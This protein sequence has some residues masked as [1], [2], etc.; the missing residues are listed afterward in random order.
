M[1]PELVGILAV[2]VFF[3]LVMLRVP[4]AFA[5]FI[6]SASGII[7]LVG[8]PGF[9]HS[10][11]GSTWSWGTNFVMLAVPL[12]ILMGSFAF[13]GGLSRDLYEVL[14]KLIGRLPGGLA[15]ASVGACAGFA[16]CSGS[17]MA[18]V[19]SVGKVSYG[20]M[21]RFNYSPRLATGCIAAGGTLGTIIPPSTLLII[22]GMLTNTSVGALFMA[23]I[24]PGLIIAGLYGSVILIRAIRSP[25]LAP[26]GPYVPWK[27]RLVLL[28]RLLPAAVLVAIIIGG[29][30]GGVFTPSEAAAVGSFVTFVYWVARKRFT[31]PVFIESL[32]EAARFTGMIFLVIFGAML[33]NRLVAISGLAALMSNWLLGLSVPST[34]Y[35]IMLL[36]LYLPLGMFMDCVGM[37][38]LTLPFFMPIFVA[39]GLN[40]V[41][42][43]VLIVRAMEIGNMTPPLGLNVY[44]IHGVAKDVPLG[45]CF[46]G[47]M[48]FVLVDVAAIAIFVAF[49]QIS[50]F[51]PGLI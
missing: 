14:F 18:T 30:Y 36:L 34:F 48:P 3:L 13:H 9:L 17:S 29:I 27:E 28:P 39:S 47:I 7:Y 8:L 5:F 31:L 37:V 49:P 21:R 46:R 15:L 1:S 38:V 2:V 32:V 33:F 10:F 35:V 22:Y 44:I 24:F 12:F 42:L 11:V 20:E 43:G 25:S 41:W 50:L 4:L 6:V 19:A 23:G 16:A 26:R 40:F 51:I 45:E